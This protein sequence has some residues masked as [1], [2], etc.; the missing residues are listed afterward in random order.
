MWQKLS[1]ASSLVVLLLLFA[2]SS[3]SACSCELP[4]PACQ[5]FWKAEAV[6]IGTV[7]SV[8]TSNKSLVSLEALAIKISVDDSFRGVSSNVVELFT[9]NV[10]SSC[11]YRFAVGQQ[12]LVYAYVGDTGRLTTNR[13][14]RTRPLTQAAEDLDYLRGLA[15]APPGST[16][17][18]EVR[19]IR[20][21]SDGGSTDSPF[22]DIPVLIENGSQRY[23]TL[24]DSQGNFILSG[25]SPGAY[26][27]SLEL[28]KGL[29]AGSEKN[30][31]N[32]AD[33]GCAFVNFFVETDGRL[34][35]RV[36]DR[37]QNPVPD[38]WL[39]LTS[40]D[41]GKASG[42]TST[43]YTNQEGV[44]ELS[45]IPPGRYI[46]QIRFDKR[47][48]Q[49]QLPFPT[50]YYPGVSDPNQATAIEIGEGQHIDN[51]DLTMPDLPKQRTVEGVV[52]TS[53]GRLVT[54]AR[55]TYQSDSI[56]YD[57]LPVSA[58]GIFTVKVYEGTPLA[59]QARVD[60]GNGKF[61][62]SDWLDIPATGDATGL[63]LVI[64]GHLL[65]K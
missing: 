44:Y 58:A 2:E 15:M 34:S 18:G 20:R 56:I 35:G 37:S 6:F 22:A 52:I 19:R 43:A 55:V 16:I 5:T 40:A 8:K 53:E 7:L 25:L 45:R 38:A 42:F 60:L 26:I 36:V 46:L 54:R 48:K 10:G 50:M 49:G 28:S 63:R 14:T 27:V 51:Y 61:V 29:R 24:T 41:R 12:Y 30:S 31:V 62:L 13:C 39:F 64:P 1:L 65:P 4:K 47:S 33:R 11:G 21:S 23:R 9:G 3:A 57:M 17:K 59:I 32:I